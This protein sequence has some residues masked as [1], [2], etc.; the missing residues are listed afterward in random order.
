MRRSGWSSDLW[1]LLRAVAAG[2]V[3]LLTVGAVI[4]FGSA[5]LELVAMR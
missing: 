4:S 2:A 5:A 1:P 3:L